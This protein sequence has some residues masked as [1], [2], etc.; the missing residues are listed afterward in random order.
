MRTIL[1]SELAVR[2]ADLWLNEWLLLCAGTRDDFNA[3]TVA[4]GSI[5]GMWN[6][7]FVQIAVRHSRHTFGFLEEHPHFTLSAFGEKGR[8]ALQLLGTRSGRDGDKI[9]DSGLTVR[10]SRVV[11]APGFEEAR[12]ILEC[13]K[14]YWQ[15]MEPEHF[16]DGAIAEC[17]PENDYHRIYYGK[18]LSVEIAD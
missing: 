8:E 6:E 10:P 16:L 12:L 1:P 13:E 18:I 4:W 14:T 17:Y 2:P 3:M 11:E 7:P 9:A 5:G 15:D